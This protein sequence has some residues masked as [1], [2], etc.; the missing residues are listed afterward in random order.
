MGADEEGTHERLQAHFTELVHPKIDGHR[1]RVVTNTGDGLL[2][3]FA[4]VIDAVRCAAEI[5]RGMIDRA[6]AYGLRGDTV[7]AAAELAEARKLASDDRYSSI[8]R[9]KAADI[10][11]NTRRSESN[12]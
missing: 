7:R 6:S 9:L 4:S 2:A 1:G 10:S 3:Q 12:P 11:K 8:A 5:Q